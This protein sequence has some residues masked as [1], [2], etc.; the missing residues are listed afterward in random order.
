M[1]FERII[2]NGYTL[3]DGFQIPPGTFVGSPS[4]AIAMNPEVYPNPEVFDGWRHEKMLQ[5]VKK[6]PSA[7]GRT[8]W[9]SANLENMAFGYGRHACPGR[10]FADYEI[11]L[12]IAHLL[13]A[14]D[15]EYVKE[16]KQRPAN[17]NAETQMIPN[18]QTKIRMCKR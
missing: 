17:L 7:A 10:F 12:I 4:Q 11:K 6:D 9:A 8:K 15:F 1:T 14:Y 2:H 18:H 16:Q 5:A 3:S 13:S